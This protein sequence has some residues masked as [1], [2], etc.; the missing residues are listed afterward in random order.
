M[1]HSSYKD[2]ITN[3]CAVT[4]SYIPKH[5]IK[6]AFDTVSFSIPIC[7][8][9]ASKAYAFRSTFVSESLDQF[10]T[11]D[12][13]KRLDKTVTG[14]VRT[15][16]D[17]IR[18]QDEALRKEYTV[19]LRVPV[20]TKNNMAFT[21]AEYRDSF[22]KPSVKIEKCD[23]W[24]IRSM[25]SLLMRMGLPDI[26]SKVEFSYNFIPTESNDCRELFRCIE[27]IVHV[28]WGSH[29]RS[30]LDYSVL[31][32]GGRNRRVKLYMRERGVN[33]R[34]RQYVRLEV[35]LNSQFLKRRG[36][37]CLSDLANV[38][39]LQPLDTL[40]FRD[41]GYAGMLRRRMRGRFFGKNFDKGSV[42]IDEE[43]VAGGLG[44]CLSVDLQEDNVI[45]I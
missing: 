21:V 7:L 6:I 37:R 4:L 11:K 14:R 36:L 40:T 33:V 28:K 26:L 42:I 15:L 17:E 39:G 31:L 34:K 30:Y 20:P 10:K 9:S 13:M 1:V 16:I 35:T 22:R 19:T 27:R 38:S 43:P 18:I 5:I 41:D 24:I 2:T 32:F 12:H 44:E 29:Y 3:H 45:E 8:Y 23:S 25:N